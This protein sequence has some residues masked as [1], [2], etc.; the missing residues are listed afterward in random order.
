M[1]ECLLLV[2]E[3]L[4]AQ[5]RQFDI[6]RWRPICSELDRF[7]PF[8]SEP[9][10][11]ML[12]DQLWRDED[13]SD[14]VLHVEEKVLY[15]VL[16]ALVVL[17]VAGDVGWG[18][19]LLRNEGVQ[20]TSLLDVLLSGF[21]TAAMWSDK[22][23]TVQHQRDADGSVVSPEGKPVYRSQQS[24]IRQVV[25]IG[26]EVYQELDQIAAAWSAA[27]F[28]EEV[29]HLVQSRVVKTLTDHFLDGLWLVLR[30]EG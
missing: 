15:Y 23:G 3:V 25:R 17:Q 20:G 6:L 19:V 12:F 4:A 22:I 10:V 29:G 21:W 24:F 28:V 27:F 16:K 30:P 5:G 26:S 13:V 11:F 14:P 1:H 18:L 8:L 7:R 9:F 2:A